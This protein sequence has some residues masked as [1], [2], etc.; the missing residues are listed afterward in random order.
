MANSARRPLTPGIEALFLTPDQSI[1]EVVECLDLTKRSIALVVNPD[2]RLVGTITE[3]EIRRAILANQDLEGPARILLDAKKGTRFEQP[4]TAAVGTRTVQLLQM[5]RQAMLRHIPLLD[6]EGR[7]V[8]L[9]CLEQLIAREEMPVR[10][11]VMAGGLGTRLQPLTHEVPKPML[12]VG[13]RPLLELIVEQLSRAGISRVSLSTRYKEE[14]IKNHFGNGKNFGVEISYLTEDQPLG[15]AGVL[16]T[17]APLKEPLLVING[18][19]LT[20]VDFQAMLDFHCDHNADMTVAVRQH[21]FRLPYGVVDTDGVRVKSIS[22]KPLIRRFIN[23]GIYLLNPDVC[24][25]VPQNQRFDMPDLI[26][27]L[28]AEGR[29]IVGYPIRE[30][31]LDIGIS[32]DYKKAQEYSRAEG[33]PSP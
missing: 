5:M 27:S 16:G 26:N 8:D 14:I 17:L 11:M 28:L 25:F 2:K 19:I 18:D 7:V 6:A 21:E 24:R 4:L 33:H 29:T 31:W 22:E 13:D 32:E 30:Y 9:A 10:A 15:T 12:P 23:A 20:G 3:G 1:R